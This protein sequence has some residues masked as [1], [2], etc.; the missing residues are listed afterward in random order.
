MGSS[1][2]HHHH[3][4]GLVPRGSHMLASGS[5]WGEI[6][7]YLAF[8]R[9][10]YKF[11]LSD[12]VNKS[13]LNED[14]TININGKGN[15]SA[16]GGGSDNVDTLIE[17]GRYNTKYNYLKRME[18]YYPNAMAYFDKVTINPQGNDFGGGSPR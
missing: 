15:Y 3:S 9:D 4:S 6:P 18:K 1:H 13:D 8:P 2:H 12:T 10:G 7:S 16:V 17:K 14:G 11:S 5:E